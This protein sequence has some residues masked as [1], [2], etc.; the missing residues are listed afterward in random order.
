M[1]PTRDSDDGAFHDAAL[2]WDRL[3]GTPALR[4]LTE[5][6]LVS[7]N[8]GLLSASDSATGMRVGSIHALV[9]II[10]EQISYLALL[11]GAMT[12]AD[13]AVWRSAL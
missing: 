12:Q 11:S 2:V 5:S 6:E 4:L 8:L 1:T 7:T 9:P 13:M 10:G 3:A